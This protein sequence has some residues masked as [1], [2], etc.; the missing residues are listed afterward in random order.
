MVQDQIRGY[1]Q[2]DGS[3]D[4]VVNEMHCHDHEIDLY[5]RATRFDFDKT[6]RDARTLPE[7]PYAGLWS[8][9]VSLFRPGEDIK[10]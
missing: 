1:C 6:T 9:S 2:I 10:P 5:E 7:N 8:T 4:G 3:L